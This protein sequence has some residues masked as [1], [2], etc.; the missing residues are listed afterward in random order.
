MSEK[1]RHYTVG[2]KKELDRRETTQQRQTIFESVFETRP[3]TE[4]DPRA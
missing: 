1:A 3:S 4:F 2:K